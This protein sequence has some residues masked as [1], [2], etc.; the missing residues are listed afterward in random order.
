M[1][2]T[3]LLCDENRDDEMTA[4]P[5][6]P[7][8][9]RQL[10]RAKIDPEQGPGSPEA[11]AQ[12]LTMVNE[13]YR[14]L[15]D[16]RSLLNR[17]LEL[18]TVEMEMLRRRVEHQRDRLSAIV[19]TI[20]EALSHFGVLAQSETKSG[21]TTAI[22]TE[23]THRLQAIL[24]ESSI[25]EEHSSDISIIRGNLVRLA[26]QIITLMTETAERAELKKELEVARAV[27]QLLVPS[28][29]VIERSRLQ[30]VGYFQPA[31]ECGGDWWTVS[32]LAGGKVLT[33]IG[34]V[35]GHGVSAAIITG[36]AKASCELAIEI[37]RGEIEAGQLL[38]LM[39]AALFRTAQRQVM[40]T[41]SAVVFDP[42]AGSLSLANAG[43]PS[44]VLIRKGIIH[45]LL[46]EGA[47]LGAGPDASYKQV[48]LA[49][50]PGDLLV[51]FT[52]G[53]IECENG[54]GE[55]FTER[56]L[57]AVCQR[58]AQGGAAAVRDAVVEALSMFRGGIAA[59]DDLTF[60]ATFFR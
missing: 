22:K 54:R 59:A 18:S 16:D 19:G 56:R 26:E 40:M 24:S 44:P 52:D 36:A 14:H 50:E 2:S 10:R 29:D 7:V 32:D 11:W 55:Q 38:T 41:C 53:I 17:S 35:T 46:A 8:L 39:N 51:G 21:Q 27:S 34:D 60:V 30:I 31:T 5:I 1:I 4:R 48:Q 12:V 13:H 33:A 28:S 42:V 3:T 37:T 49:L 15:D 23:F 20:G 9:A 6:D 25:A 57:R 43:H 45:P 58:A 47:P